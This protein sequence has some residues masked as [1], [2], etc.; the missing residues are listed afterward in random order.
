MR[1]KFGISFRLTFAAFLC[2]VLSSVC[3]AINS[4]ITRHISSS[5]LL[6]GQTE[7]VVIDSR[8]T[9]KLGRAAEELIKDFDDFGDVWSINSVVISDGTVYFGTSPNGGIYKYELNK[10]TK[11]YPSQDNGYSQLEDDED[12]AEM[13]EADEH[14]SNE[15]IFALALDT[16]GRLLAGISGEMCRLCRL[17]NN[18]MEVI[19]ESDDVKYIF[20]I[21]VDKSGNIFLGTGPEGKVFRLNSLGRNAQVIYDSP[22]KNILSLAVGQDD[23]IYAGSDSRGLVYKID[24]RTKKT[25]V[26]YDSD[27]PEITS[28]LIASDVESGGS[29]DVCAGLYASATSAKIVQTQTQFAA[30]VYD[31]SSSGRPETEAE[32]GSSIEQSEGSRNLQIANTE[33]PTEKKPPQGPPLPDKRAKPA[34][35]SYI[36]NISKDG[37]VNEIFGETAIFFC[38]AE[39]NGKLLAGTGNSAQLYSVDPAME[40]Q[41][42]IYEDKQASQITA[43]APAGQDVY[44]GTANPAK[45]IKLT[46]GF[47]FEGVYISDLIDAGQPSKWGK[48]QL[49]ADIPRGCKVLMSCRSGN[50]KDVNDTT[51]SDW[52]GLV[53]ITEPVQLNCPL[54]RFCQYKLVLRSENGEKSPQIREIA[55]ANTIPNLAP[56]VEA[57]TVTPI[58]GPTKE[59]FLKINYKTS[60]DN[61][62]DLVYKID[63]RKTGRINWIELEDQAEGSGF[64]W[65]GKTVEDGRYEVR[66]TASDAKSNTTATKLTGSRI[67]QQVVVDNTGPAVMK[68]AMTPGF[69]GD[70]KYQILKV[71]VW[72]E[73]SA[74]DK[75]EYTIDSNTDWVASVPDDMVYDTMSENFT[76]QIEE[77]DKLPKGD[78]VLTIRVKDAVGNTTYKTLDFNID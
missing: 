36:Y 72:D 51:F 58:S 45:L 68:M 57:I 15:H 7:N 39:Q 47:A 10:L 11:I 64:E 27:Q 42:V 55:V 17:E 3:P 5:D 21:A 23:C 2:L 76:I 50:V 41:A 28:L 73:L 18:E 25:T 31:G 54:G 78:H 8:G 43:M 1:N 52:S 29:S 33:K 69:E 59:G 70:E 37:F 44:L 38:L 35:A 49:D 12:G 63:F 32:N 62:D 34:K 19:F 77:D 56:K 14:L 4:K 22:D 71:E 13:V 53:E 67:S 48:L 65:D 75:L 46:S 66:V 6:K 16:S 30:S 26:L 61:E 74:I 24:P 9:I 40:E 20:A 60:D